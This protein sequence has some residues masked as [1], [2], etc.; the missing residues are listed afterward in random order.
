[1]CAMENIPIGGGPGPSAPDNVVPIAPPAEPAEREEAAE[2]DPAV[3]SIVVESVSV[4]ESVPVVGVEQRDDDPDAA[5]EEE[6]L[7]WEEVMAREADAPPPESEPGPR[8]NAEL[9]A[10]AKEAVRVGLGLTVF[11]ANAAADGL[12]STVPADGTSPE[13]EASEPL[14][15][16]IGAGLGFVTQMADLATKALDAAAETV[17]PAASWIAHPPFMRGAAEAAAGAVRLMDGRW[18]MEEAETRKAAEVFIGRLIPEITTTLLEHLD[19]NQILEE[20]PIEAIVDRVDVD[21]I[22]ERV[23]LD[24]VVSRIDVNEIAGR[25]DLD[26]VAAGIDVNAVVSRVDMDAIIERIDVTEIVEDVIDE[27]DLPGIIRASTDRMAGETVEV[28]RLRSMDGD[29]LVRRAVDRLFRRKRGI[30]GSD[31][32]G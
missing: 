32:D 21:G 28:V 5:E 30:E 15:T 27:V 3:E 11:V 18:Q 26:A 12:R 9:I 4:V 7:S 14:S 17:E 22:V 19:L 10:M 25:I 1:M 29:A 23:D 20:L 24:A 6:V 2:R 31:G 8:P 13:G 16:M